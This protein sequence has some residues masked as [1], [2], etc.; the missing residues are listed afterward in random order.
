MN[1]SRAARGRRR[2]RPAP[3]SSVR[4]R[5]LL[6][7]AQRTI[8]RSFCDPRGLPAASR[9]SLAV[10]QALALASTL[11]LFCVGLWEIDAPFGPGREQLSA[12]LTLA[13]DNM[14]RWGTALPVLEPRLSPPTTA[15]VNLEHPFGVYWMAA[16]FRALFGHEAWVCR[17]PAVL[18]S[19]LSPAL[20][21]ALGRALYGPLAG[22]VAAVAFAVTP[23]TLLLS[24]LTGFE[25]PLTFAALLTSLGYVRLRQTGRRSFG[26][27]ALLG[28]VLC[29]NTDWPGFGFV[30]A[31]LGLAFV[32]VFVVRPPSHDFEPVARWFAWGAVL[33]AVIAGYYALVFFQVGALSPVFTPEPLL[34]PRRDGELRAMLAARRELIL[35][36]FTMLVPYVT[37]LLSPL[38]LVRAL[39]RRRDVELVPLAFFLLGALQLGWFGGRPSEAV[40]PHAFAASFALSLGFGFETLS[41]RLKATAVGALVRLLLFAVAPV[42]LLP[43]ALRLLLSSRS[44]SVD[45]AL[46]A[47]VEV[48]DGDKLFAMASLSPRIAAG[49]AVVI[50]ANLRPAPWMSWA[51]ERPVRSRKSDWGRDADRYFVI[52]ARF[53]STRELYELTQR[54]ALAAVGPLFVFDRTQPPAPASALALTRREPTLF[55]RL[56]V[57]STRAQRE[58]APDPFATYELREHLAQLPN[59]APVAVPQSFEQLRIAHNAAVAAGDIATAIGF[60][61]RLLAG[62]DRRPETEY[63]DG[64]RFLGL[65]LESGNSRLLTLYFQSQGPAEQRFVVSSEL[66]APP[67]LSLVPWSREKREIGAPAYPPRDSWRPGYVYSVV[68]ELAARPGVERLA[69]SWVATTADVPLV[70]KSGAREVTLLVLP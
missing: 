20:L 11:W 55:E 69:G 27:L 49:A 6:G 38:M 18:L 13:G 30:A 62:I 48:P 68:V 32:R 7:G 58:L 31:L 54:S 47:A 22:G 40:L 53:A 65:R 34:A 67:A 10:G 63:R 66:V 2:A 12:T 56:L 21:Y 23:I 57:S 26:L 24:Q 29:L 46:G 25:V 19:A 33:T 36:T 15:D 17:L 9:L 3:L 35:G 59:P 8:R 5:R 41:A 37:A 64:T 16:A 39:F 70:T 45:G 61:Q 4:V 44:T 60:R 50:D 43:D 42:V 14:L 51:L 28:L 52:D 1:E